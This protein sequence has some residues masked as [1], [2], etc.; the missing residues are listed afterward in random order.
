MILLRNIAAAIEVVGRPKQGRRFGIP[1]GGAFDFVSHAEA[2]TLFGNRFEAPALEVSFGSIEL[3]AQGDTWLGWTGAD[4]PRAAQWLEDGESLTVTTAGRAYLSLPGGVVQSGPAFFSL[5]SRLE[6]PIQPLEPRD[7]PRREYIRILPGPQS[8]VVPPTF[9][10]AEWTVSNALNR[11]GIRLEGPAF[12]HAVEITSEP[13]CPGTIQL[14]SGGLP[15]LLGPDG[16][17]IGGYP[18]V[19]VVLHEDLPLVGQ[20][21]PG[22]RFRFVLTR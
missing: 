17:T 18:K 15:I 4:A 21:R 2:N 7:E 3:V 19:G 6:P 8:D 11:V 9:F 14:P 5:A 10:D 12:P 22:D 13:A 20:L 16:P 1:P